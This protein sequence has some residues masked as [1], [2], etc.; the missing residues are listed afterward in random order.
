MVITANV[1]R[2]MLV[3]DGKWWIVDGGRLVMGR[4]FGVRILG[5][6]SKITTENFYRWQ[7]PL[8]RPY[9]L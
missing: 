4:L 2:Q 6:L 8:G 1:S 9:C 7:L 3:N 5:D